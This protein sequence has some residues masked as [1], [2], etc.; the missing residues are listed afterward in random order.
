MYCCVG[1]KPEIIFTNASQVKQCN[2]EKVH[3]NSL[4]YEQA[5]HCGMLVNQSRFLLDWTRLYEMGSYFFNRNR[6]V[7]LVVFRLH[8]E[9][10][11]ESL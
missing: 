10:R 2:E 3:E 5:Y 1:L 9:V 7:L 4:R 8:V 6:L 11:P